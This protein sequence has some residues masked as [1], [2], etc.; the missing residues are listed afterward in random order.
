MGGHEEAIYDNSDKDVCSRCPVCRELTAHG[1]GVD[2]GVCG[3]KLPRGADGHR[4]WAQGLDQLLA[5]LRAPRHGMTA[6][7]KELSR[8]LDSIEHGDPR[9]ER[10]TRELD[11]AVLSDNL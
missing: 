7:E 8:K 11:E 6:R 2:D 1:G 5:S 4:E 10:L 9:W 3:H